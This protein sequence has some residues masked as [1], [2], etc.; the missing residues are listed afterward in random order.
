MGRFGAHDLVEA[1]VRASGVGIEL[2]HDAFASDRPDERGVD[3]AAFHPSGHVLK[4]RLPRICQSLTEGGFARTH[5]HQMGQGVAPKDVEIHAHRSE[6]MRGVEVAVAVQVMLEAPAVLVVGRVQHHHPQV[7]QVGALGVG[8]GAEDA[9]L[10]HV[11]DPQL[12]TVVAAVF[13]HDAVALRFLGHLNEVDAFLVGGGDGHFAGGVQPLPH[14][15]G[16][17]G[18]VPFPRG[19]DQGEVREFGGAGGLPG[20]IA[21]CEGLGR[22]GLELGNAVERPLNL[23]GIDVADGADLGVPLTHKPFEHVD[24]AAPSVAQPDEG[25]P[26]LGQGFRGQV[27]HRSLQLGGLNALGEF[28]GAQWTAGLGS[29][30]GHQTAQSQQSTPQEIPSLHALKVGRGR[31]E[32]EKNGLHFHLLQNPRSRWGWGKTGNA[33]DGVADEAQG[34]EADGGRH[35]AD[36]PVLAFVDLQLDPRGRDVGAVPNGGRALPGWVVVRQE[37]RFGGAG[38]EDLALGFH[39]H[40]ALERAEVFR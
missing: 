3:I 39:L 27:K 15:M 18:G 14:G 38:G 7:V 30:S 36:L 23:V 6:T 40:G 20:V 37:P 11:E 2:E 9:F 21:S 17:H 34:G 26:H 8:Q 22:G 29:T 25:N 12:L 33:P 28:R 5:A 1:I 19:A 13:E 32:S 35:A 4:G 24:E 16:G 10:D 31:G